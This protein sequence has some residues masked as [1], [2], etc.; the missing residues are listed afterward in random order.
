VPVL[1]YCWGAAQSAT[2]EM[3]AQVAA[4][5]WESLVVPEPPEPQPSPLVTIAPV[6]APTPAVE[7]ARASAW[8]A[9][10]PE[11]Q[12]VHLRAQRF[13]RVQVAQMRLN[14]A[15]AVQSGRS[16]RDLYG[17]LRAHIDDAREVF[18]QKFFAQSSHMVD[19]IHVEIV[20]TL[21]HDDA[22]LLGKDYPGP[23]V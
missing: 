18:R 14:D 19:Y 11:E 5:V 20:R 4:G 15:A 10:P 17:A 1:L 9:L 23:L 7:P 6:L 3:L 21:A 12:A 2:L 13:A 16:N 8:D 22:D